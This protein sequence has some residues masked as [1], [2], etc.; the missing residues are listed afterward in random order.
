MNTHALLRNRSPSAKVLLEGAQGILLSVL[1]GTY[2]YVTSS[3]CSLDGLAAGA[4][5]YVGMIDHTYVV[6]KAPYMTR[7]GRGPFPTELGGTE[8]DCWCNGGATEAMELER[9]PNA[10]INSTE[11]LEQGVAM[12]RAGGEYGATTKRPR[13]TGWLD[14][15]MLR[16]VLT[17]GGGLNPART[18]IVLTKPDVLNDVDELKLCIA[19]CYRG[20]DYCVAGRMV[21]NGDVLDAA[22]MDADVLARVVPIYAIMPG[23]KRSLDGVTSPAE[24]PDNLRAYITR[25]EDEVG[26][27]VDVVSVGPDR[28]EMVF[29]E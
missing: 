6:V 18:S 24:L 7:V 8:S 19:Y 28:T 13:C 1:H 20:S 12:R 23:W 2:P 9:F 11:S 26:F 15:L 3:D 25:I 29:M 10:D 14:L 5:I 21:S 22:I 16:H 27:R 17:C 4:D